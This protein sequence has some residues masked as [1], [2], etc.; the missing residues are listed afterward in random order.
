MQEHA[1]ALFLLEQTAFSPQ[2]EGLQ[3]SVLTVVMG[4]AAEIQTCGE[5]YRAATRT[6]TCFPTNAMHYDAICKQTTIH[7]ILLSLTCKVWRHP[8]CETK[9]NGGEPTMALE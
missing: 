1:A 3:G 4:G 8:A 7:Y 6:I 9:Y 5:E 2:G